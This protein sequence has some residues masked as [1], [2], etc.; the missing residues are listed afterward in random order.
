MFLEHNKNKQNFFERTV[1]VFYE[2]PLPDFKEGQNVKY[3][4]QGNVL[5]SYEIVEDEEGEK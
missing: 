5:K 1:L 3:I 4:T 2:K